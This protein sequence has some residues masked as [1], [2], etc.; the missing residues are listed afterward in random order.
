MEV[1]YLI[2]LSSNKYYVYNRYTESFLEIYLDSK[3][4]GLAIKI[5]GGDTMIFEPDRW[6]KKKILDKPKCIEKY[7]SSRCW[8]LN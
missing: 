5:N 8:R 3:N 7:V 1:G 2:L 6:G 4:N